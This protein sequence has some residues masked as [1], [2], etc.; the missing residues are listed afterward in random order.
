MTEV[1]Q[2]GDR[3]ITA[4]EIPKLLK[5]YQLMP[6]F[7]QGLVID[8]AVADYT[9]TDEEK[10]AAIQ[11]FCQ[12]HQ[13]T[14][15]EAQQGWLK[16]HAMTPAEF[17][18]VAVRPVLLQKYKEETWGRKVRSH[19]MT[20]KSS[21]DQVVYSLIRTK[22]DGLAQELYYRIQEGEQTFEECAR[23]YSQGP[24]ARTGGKLGPVPLNRPHPAIGKLLSVSQPGQLWPPRALAEWFIII[25][26]EEFHPAQLD[27]A[28]RAR[29][30]DELF[31]GWL[32][33]EVQSLVSAEIDRLSS[34]S[35]SA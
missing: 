14:S 21:L 24:E 32:Q 15:P 27:D 26:L 29:M 22:D 20:R 33:T 10:Q 23:E 31:A 11:K 17:E 6:Q 8:R 12:Q 19:F 2:V 13:L 34:P 7:L 5:R 1:F 3:E 4:S 30:L 35:P 28:M 25:R 9:C 18:E 16:A